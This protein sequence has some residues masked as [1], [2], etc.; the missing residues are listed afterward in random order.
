MSLAASCRS[1]DALGHEH[2]GGRVDSDVLELLEEVRAEA[3]R[4]QVPAEVSVLVDPSVEVE[5][6]DILQRDDVSFH[7]DDLGDVGD[8]PA[9]VLQA[10]LM[11]D[12]VDGRRD[13]L[14]NSA[15]GEV[16]PG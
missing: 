2:S 5:H 14:A 16:D 3:G 6:E 12:Q 9:S 7:A 11:D 13:L 8:P 4:L 10:P 1:H 15:D